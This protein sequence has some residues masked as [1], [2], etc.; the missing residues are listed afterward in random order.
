M[1]DM[2]SI[3]S[4]SMF[5][6]FKVKSFLDRFWY[7]YNK[8]LDKACEPIGDCSCIQQPNLKTTAYLPFI[9]FWSLKRAQWPEHIKPS[10]HPHTLISLFIAQL[11]WYFGHFCT[12]S[13]KQDS[14]CA[15]SVLPHTNYINIFSQSRIVQ[16]PHFDGNLL[17]IPPAT[18]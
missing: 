6:C 14:A 8:Q 3:M 12:A 16:R 13:I 9:V 2:M 5:A 18:H 10:C 17:R 15:H 1:A 4:R 7:H 11:D